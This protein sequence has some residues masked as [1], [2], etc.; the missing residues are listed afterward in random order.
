VGHPSKRIE[1]LPCLQIDLGDD[2]MDMWHPINL[3]A[4]LIILSTL[5]SGNVRLSIEVIFV[6]IICSKGELFEI[7]Y[8]LLHLGN[9]YKVLLE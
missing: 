1:L 9:R 8:Q 5:N 2:N 3:A 6:L 7:P 4:G